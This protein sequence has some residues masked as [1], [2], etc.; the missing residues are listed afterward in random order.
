M[1]DAE[2]PPPGAVE[3][4]FNTSPR[5]ERRDSPLSLPSAERQRVPD[6]APG[7]ADP[8]EIFGPRFLKRNKTTSLSENKNYITD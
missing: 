6:R 3:D 4:R 2:T 7:N 8:E 1:R 5:R